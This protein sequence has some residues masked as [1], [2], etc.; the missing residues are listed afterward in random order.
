MFGWV[1]Q[2]ATCLAG[3]FRVLHVWQGGSECY[4]LYGT[5]G[6]VVQSAGWVVQRAGWVVQSAGWVVHRATC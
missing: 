3:W 6:W 4:M 5:I 2:S 1:V